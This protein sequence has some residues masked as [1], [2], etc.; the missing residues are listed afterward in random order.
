[1]VQKLDQMRSCGPNCSVGAVRSE[2]SPTQTR[3][4]NRLS[5]STALVCPDH[6]WAYSR[7]PGLLTLKMR[8]FNDRAVA[9]AVRAQNMEVPGVDEGTRADRAHDGSNC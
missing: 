4:R 8:A 5:Q 1:M 6:R 7:D 2:K 9:D 3:F